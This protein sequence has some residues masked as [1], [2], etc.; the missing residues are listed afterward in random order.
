MGERTE[1]IVIKISGSLLYPPDKEY[2]LK[3]KEIIIEAEDNYKMM[4]I[5]VGGGPIA[6]TIINPLKELGV[7]NS[8]LDIIGI[9]S[10][11]LNALTL[12]TLLYPHSPL[13]IPS[14]I[15]EA[16]SIAAKGLIPV[17]GGLQ[18]GQSTNA[19]AMALAE[20]INAHK[21]INMLNGIEGVYTKH[22]E[23]PEARLL[24]KTTIEQ[25][26]KIIED[27]PQLPG[28]YDLLDHIA[29]KIAQRTKIK[30]HFINGRNLENLEK[31]LKNKKVGT[32]ILP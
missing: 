24:E 12:A 3:L 26:E 4:G 7:D 16:A 8:K 22:P 29:L 6:R 1:S 11:R 23:S 14:T 5:V 9:T 27:Y 10:A 13:I 15:E 25:L 32:I 2:L 31:A 30:I 17:M 20:A 18:P 28:K 21:V 19:V